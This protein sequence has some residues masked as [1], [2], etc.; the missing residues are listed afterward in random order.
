M[1]KN[2][3]AHPQP[4]EK[5]AG[6]RIDEEQLATVNIK[7]LSLRK[8]KDNFFCLKRTEQK[9][10]PVTRRH[11]SIPYPLCTDTIPNDSYLYI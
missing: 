1:G 2:K 3:K 9:H 10:C 8:S 5:T 11:C 4:I 6:Y 7:H